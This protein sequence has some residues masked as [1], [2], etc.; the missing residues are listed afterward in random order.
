ML[1][2]LHLITLRPD[3]THF[4]ILTYFVKQFSGALGILKS[5]GISC[6]D[7]GNEEYKY[8]DNPGYMASGG[9]GGQCIGYLNI[10]NAID[11]EDGGNPDFQRLCPCK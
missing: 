8:R 1:Y 7:D 10:P 4:I 11:C 9:W 3:I 5:K 2:N 6:I